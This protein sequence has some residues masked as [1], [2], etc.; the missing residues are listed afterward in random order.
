MGGIGGE[1]KL[2]VAGEILE[3]ICMQE[4][5]L[6]EV[7]IISQGRSMS[8]L[9]PTKIHIMSRTTQDSPW[10]MYMLSASAMMY[11]IPSLV[12]GQESNQ[13]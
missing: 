6:I 7:I 13:S 12:H 4:S 1:M 10:K 11:L 5:K 2:A 8:W 3:K 9:H